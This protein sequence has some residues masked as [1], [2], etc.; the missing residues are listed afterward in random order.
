MNAIQVQNLLRAAPYGVASAD[1]ELADDEVTIRG[2]LP[3][4]RIMTNSATLI[5]AIGRGWKILLWKDAGKGP[6]LTITTRVDRVVL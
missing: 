4:D 1:M 2:G 5:S 3:I 6:V